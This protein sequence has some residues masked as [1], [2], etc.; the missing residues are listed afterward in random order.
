MFPF[1][2]N[3]MDTQKDHFPYKALQEGSRGK[4]Q[5]CNVL[6]DSMVSLVHMVPVVLNGG[7]EG[8]RRICETEREEKGEN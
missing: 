2:R 3:A 6:G 7:G 1:V 8:G 4:K 5:P